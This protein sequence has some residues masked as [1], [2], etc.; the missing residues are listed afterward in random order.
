MNQ[1][2]KFLLEHCVFY[3]SR[4]YL[5]R[6]C[7]GQPVTVYQ[8][9]LIADLKNFVF[10]FVPMKINPFRLLDKRHFGRGTGGGGT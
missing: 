2:V 5:L 3:W 10:V 4:L 1:V 6:K 7:L 9:N 8:Y